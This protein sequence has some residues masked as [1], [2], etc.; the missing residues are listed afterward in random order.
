MKRFDEMMM[1]QASE[2]KEYAMRRRFEVEPKKRVRVALGRGDFPP[3][4]WIDT[5]CGVD[6][7]SKSEFSPEIKAFETWDGSCAVTCFDRASFMALFRDYPT[8]N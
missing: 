5:F 2:A 1:I 8:G 7:W 6:H 4:A 3:I